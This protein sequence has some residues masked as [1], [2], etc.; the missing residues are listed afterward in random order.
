MVLHEEPLKVEETDL[1][2]IVKK[3]KSAQ[4]VEDGI[5]YHMEHLP[6]AHSLEEF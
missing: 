6:P 3:W 5:T 4:D 1:Y 2:E